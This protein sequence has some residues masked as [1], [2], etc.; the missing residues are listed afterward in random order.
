MMNPTQGPMTMPEARL[1][2][3]ELTNVGGYFEEVGDH[4]I[5]IY[6]MGNFL[7]FVAA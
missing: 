4:F 5:I 7:N 1:R 6:L 3:S 2:L